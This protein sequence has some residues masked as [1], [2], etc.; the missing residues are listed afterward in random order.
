MSS[1][2]DATLE[3]SSSTEAKNIRKLKLT[4][5]HPIIDYPTTM[6]T[7]R[8]NDTISA[9][10]L[11]H[12]L[13]SRRPI[14]LFKNCTSDVFCTLKRSTQVF[15]APISAKLS[16]HLYL[17]PTMTW[18]K[19][20]NVHGLPQKFCRQPSKTTNVYKTSRLGQISSGPT[21]GLPPIK[22]RMGQPEQDSTTQNQ[23]RKK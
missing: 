16:E 22:A 2:L 9:Q 8:G 23:V 4:V 13:S 3:Q 21:P 19:R 20:I 12:Q 18:K 14:L 11:L 1:T 6:S 10:Y 7:T 17:L 15:N 5:Q